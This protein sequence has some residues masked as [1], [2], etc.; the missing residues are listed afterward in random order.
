MNLNKQRRHLVFICI[1]AFTL[2]IVSSVVLT[3]VWCIHDGISMPQSGRISPTEYQALASW[4]RDI[5][6]NVIPG[7]SFGY[8]VIAILILNLIFRVKPGAPKPFQ[9]HP[10]PHDRQDRQ[11]HMLN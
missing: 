6:F 2:W 10:G 1:F 4:L 8:F 5:V 11:E 3:A 9:G 7:L